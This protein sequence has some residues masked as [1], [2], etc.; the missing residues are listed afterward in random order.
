[1]SVC[2]VGFGFRVHQISVL[3]EVKNEGRSWAEVGGRTTALGA[4]ERIGSMR[5]ADRSPPLRFKLES[6]PAGIF[7]GPSRTRGPP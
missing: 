4:G 6:L 1:M 5:M 7:C 3:P 2:G